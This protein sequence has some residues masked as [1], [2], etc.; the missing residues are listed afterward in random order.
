[1]LTVWREE[2]M[3]AGVGV[4]DEDLILA[5]KKRSQGN[6]AVRRND[7]NLVSV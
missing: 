3:V 2:L 7:P 5:E 6:F 4:E 1:M